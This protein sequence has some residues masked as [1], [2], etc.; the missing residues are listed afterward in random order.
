MSKRIFAIVIVLVMALSAKAQLTLEKT[1]DYSLTS[2]KINQT[3]YKYFLMDVAKSECRIYNLDHTLWK[4][5]SVS[6]PAN[7]Y[8]YDI[9]FVSQYLFNSDAMV[10]LWYSA[11]EYVST[12]TSTGYYRY[13]SKVISENGNQLASVTGGAYAYV[14]PAGTDVYKFLVYAYDNSV[15]PYLIQTYLFTLPDPSSA[16]NYLS[17]QPGDP[18]PNPASDFINLPLGNDGAG[19]VIQVFGISGQKILEQNIRGESIFHLNTS[20]WSPGLYT[21]RLLNK[22]LPGQSKEFIVR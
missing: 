3:D 14:I 4:K 17:A 16:V 13:I 20:H 19:G 10:E 8:L 9:K 5:I 1:Y 12:G 22:G 6:L 21:Y 15:Y 18:F 7:Y 11:C 2:V